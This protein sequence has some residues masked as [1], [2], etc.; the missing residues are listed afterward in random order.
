MKECPSKGTC[1]KCR[2]KHHTLLHAEAGVSGSNIEIR[3]QPKTSSVVEPTSTTGQII[4]SQN[5]ITSIHSNVQESASQAVLLT[6]LVNVLDRNQKVHQ[7]RALLDCGSQVSFISQSLQN[8]LGLGVDEVSIPITGI[9]N[10]KSLMKQRCCVQIR[11]NCSDFEFNLNCLILPKITGNI[12]ANSFMTE[13]WNIPPG[14]QLADPFFNQMNT[15]DILIGMD[16]FYDLMK[17]GCLMLGENLPSLHDSQLGWL[18]GGRYSDC[19]HSGT[20]LQSLTVSSHCFGYLQNSSEV[21]GVS[22]EN[23]FTAEQQT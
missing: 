21:K 7:C 9:G 10:A 1:K 22:D 17:S 3:V 5:T 6:A 16:W 19:F 14:I 18:V 8:K 23:T 11:S 20:I 12:P 2:R 15:V 13:H 4:A